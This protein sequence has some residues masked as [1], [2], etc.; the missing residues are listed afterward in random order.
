MRSSL[1]YPAPL[2]NEPGGK[3]ARELPYEKDWDAGRVQFSKESQYF[4]QQSYRLG[5]IEGQ[6]GRKIK[7]KLKL[8]YFIISVVKSAT[9]KHIKFK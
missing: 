5:W 2:L 7:G 3:G 9:L 6:I 8:P 4:Y 1:F